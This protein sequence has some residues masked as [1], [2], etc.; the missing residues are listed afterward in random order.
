VAPQYCCH[1]PHALLRACLS[2]EH[3]GCAPCQAT[4]ARAAALPLQRPPLLFSRV[5]CLHP[6]GC[7]TAGLQ[8]INTPAI[9]LPLATQLGP[10]WHQRQTDA[11]ATTTCSIRTTA[12]L[13][14]QSSRV[15]I[16][17]QSTPFTHPTCTCTC[18]H[19][20]HAPLSEY[21]HRLRS[22]SPTRGLCSQSM[23]TCTA[24]APCSESPSGC[25]GSGAAAQ[26]FALE[27]TACASAS[28][29]R[30]HTHDALS[31]P[32]PCSPVPSVPP[33][34][35]LSADTGEGALVHADAFILTPERCG[36][37]PDD[38]ELAGWIVQQSRYV[39]GWCRPTWGRV[40]VC[41]SDNGAP[42]TLAAC[43]RPIV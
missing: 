21:V 12:T 18:P 7:Y 1:Q 34:E 20:P 3:A 30:H 26:G 16:G 42:L 11:V 10:S 33:W 41:V 28:T 13:P 19:R 2:I 22:I 8:P 35:G 36:C 32:A 5:P 9:L 29:C 6:C 4:S 24:V 37:G 27:A 38:P 23:P 17:L 14:D 25:R 39:R 40:G 31:G 43:C 15:H